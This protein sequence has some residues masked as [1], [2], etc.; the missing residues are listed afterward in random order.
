MLKQRQNSRNTECIYQHVTFLFNRGP[1]PA[2]TAL[3]LDTDNIYI[4]VEENI[5]LL[6]DIARP[7]SSAVNLKSD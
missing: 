6:L 7:L 2:E 4:S 3:C 1:T 5:H